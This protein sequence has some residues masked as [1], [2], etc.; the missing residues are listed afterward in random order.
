MRASDQFDAIVEQGAPRN[1]AFGARR[2]LARCGRSRVCRPDATNK[3]DNAIVERPD[4]GPT[5][6]VAGSVG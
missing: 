5:R 3:V 2:I 6:P 4:L 1:G